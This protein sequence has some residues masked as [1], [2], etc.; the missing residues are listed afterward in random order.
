MSLTAK[1]KQLIKQ[2]PWKQPLPDFIRFLYEKRFGKMY[3]E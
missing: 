2:E 3:L 1:Q